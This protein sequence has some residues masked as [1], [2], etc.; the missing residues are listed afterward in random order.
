MVVNSSMLPQFT[1][2]SLGLGSLSA[3]GGMNPL[4]NSTATPQ[5]NRPHYV[6]SMEEVKWIRSVVAQVGINLSDDNSDLLVES[7]LYKV[8]ISDNLSL[9]H[10]RLPHCL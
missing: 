10:Y 8:C 4:R 9:I 5:I 2:Q 3:S 1:P 6:P 7:L